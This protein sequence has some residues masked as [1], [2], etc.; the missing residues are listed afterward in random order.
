MKRLITF[1]TTVHRYL[2]LVFCLIF[3]IWFAS[4]IV[5]V[6]HRMPEYAAEERLARLPALDSAA[7]RL[8][9][10]EA[11]EAAVLSDA[12]RRVLVTSVQSRPAYRFVVDAGSVT[13]FADDGSFFEGVDRDAAMTVA[14]GAFPE[15][16]STLQYLGGLED[17][18]QWTINNRFNTSGVLHHV[19]LGDAAGTE[20]YVA[21]ASG[22]IVQKTDRSSRF[23]GYL[24][25]VMH[26]FYF[27]PLRAG[28]APL[29]N[30]LIVYGSL[31]GC[32]LCVL[33]LVIGTYRF[34]ASRRFKRGTS[35]TPYV[36]WLR[37]HHYAGLLFGL[38]TL[39]WTF[40]GLLTMTPWNLFPSA[41]PTGDQVRAIRGDGLDLN[42]FM[43]SPSEAVGELRS[44]FQPKEL[45]LLQFMG[46]PFYAAYERPDVSARPH[47]DAA[48]YA[49]GDQRAVR[50]FVSAGS[51]AP[52]IREGFTRDELLTAARAAMG[53]QEPVEVTWLTEF[54]S[55]Y[56][57]RTGGRH[58]PA[59]RAK[60]DDADQTW[61][62]L[63]STEGS[64]V[65]AEVSGS[66][67]ER[68][69]YQGLHSLDFPGLY[70]TPWAWYPLI[71]G[72]SLGGTALSVTS[73]IIAWRFLRAKVRAAA[74]P[75]RVSV[76]QSA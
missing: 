18:D 67:A 55:Y 50:V 72:L 40:S 43:L 9:P 17:P 20:V 5:M 28:R 2:G 19:A 12:P 22:E 49:P 39:T 71:I 11:L 15:S 14:A 41:G 48:R 66:R 34:S 37:W 46:T 1:L 23:W 73:L 76:R 38:V 74:Q 7:I 42:R 56:Y 26:W 59:L 68:W 51:G 62:Y 35:R 29:W 4:G 32:V 52:G 75:A 65:L 69:L 70:Q 13:V 60:F 58:L 36:G 10:A 33:G 64:V 16:R 47:Q 21:E 31:V 6:Y 3:V 30:N 57:D 8:T 25:P 61:L 53:G 54:D 63:D 44:R 27:T 24:G 45:E